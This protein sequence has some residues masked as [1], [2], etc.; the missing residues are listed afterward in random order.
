MALIRLGNTRTPKGDD[1]QPKVILRANGI[2]FT[3]AAQIKLD[4]SPGG[5]IDFALDPKEGTAYVASVP[6][7]AEGEKQLG[8]KLSALGVINSQTAHKQLG[9]IAEKAGD[10]TFV[11]SEDAIEHDGLQW[12]ALSV[13]AGIDETPAPTKRNKRE[14]VEA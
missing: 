8:R 10:D 6:A 9:A 1:G 14:E 13:Q 7:S 2:R 11:L 12:F 5:Y 3:P 4:V